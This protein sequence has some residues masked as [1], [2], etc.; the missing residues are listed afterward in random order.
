[1]AE[2]GRLER[3]VVVMVFLKNS[4]IDRSWLVVEEKVCVFQEPPGEEEVVE[5]RESQCHDVV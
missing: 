4:G 1:L 5:G 2:C 3:E